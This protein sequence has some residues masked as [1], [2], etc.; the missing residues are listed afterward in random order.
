MLSCF[1]WFFIAV[2][3]RGV[4]FFGVSGASESSES[5]S[6]LFLVFGFL[7][8]SS[9]DS[10]GLLDPEFVRFSC[11]PGIVGH[12]FTLLDIGANESERGLAELLALS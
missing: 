5:V 9:P 8:G 7:S 6:I 3:A 12:H 1:S 11:R 4:L 2:F 10:L